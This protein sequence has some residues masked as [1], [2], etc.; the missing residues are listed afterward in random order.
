MEL[1]ECLLI[2][3]DCY[4]SERTITPQGVMVHSTGADNPHVKRYVQPVAGQERYEERIG[5]LGKNENGNDWNRPGVKKCVHAFIGLM[6]DGTVGAV[7]TLPWEHR[8]WHSGSG[9]NGSANNTH[10]SFE[11]CE[12]DLTDPEYFAKVYHEAVELTAALCKE[13][14]LDPLADGVV[15]CH[16]EGARRGIASDHQDVENWFPPMGKTM[17]DFR[18]EVDLRMREEDEELTGEEIFKKLR[19]YLTAQPVPDWAK[20]ELEEAVKMG[21]TDG[22]DPMTLTPRYQAAIMAKRAA[23]KDKGTPAADE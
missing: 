8:G 13:Y 9:K 2:K 11:I 6:A 15:I 16:A 10:I 21:I 23:E 1:I 3:N 5:V 14:K 20:E 17:D 18:R 7:Q 22:G 4:K 19:D 12:D